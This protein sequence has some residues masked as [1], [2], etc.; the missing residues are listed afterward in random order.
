MQR[1]T[2]MLKLYAWKDS[3][4]NIGQFLSKER[5]SMG[6]RMGLLK[7]TREFLFPFQIPLGESHTYNE[8]TIQQLIQ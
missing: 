3:G 4:N 1:I 8:P 7:T 6:S 2:R 5:K